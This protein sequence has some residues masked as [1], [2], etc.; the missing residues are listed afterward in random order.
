MEKLMGAAKPPTLVLAH[1]KTLAAQLYAEFRDFFPENAVAYFVSYFDY[2]PP[3]ASLPRSDT[4][5]KKDRSRSDE[6][7]RLRHAA[8]HGL[9]ERGDVIVVASVSCIY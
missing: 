9:F 5:M 8:T 1:N 7:D 3:E 4:Q 6:I 2:Y